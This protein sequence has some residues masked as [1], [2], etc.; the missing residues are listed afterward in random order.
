MAAW[1]RWSD[2]GLG[3]LSCATGRCFHWECHRG[4]AK[5]VFRFGYDDQT[6]GTV[7]ISM[8]QGQ[9]SRRGRGRGRKVQNP[10]AR[11]FESNGPDV[12]IRGTAAHIAEKYST[13]ARDAAASGDSVQAENYLQHAEHYNRI[14]AAAQAQQQ[15]QQQNSRDNR[16]DDYDDDDRDEREYGSSGNNG[17]GG[18]NDQQQRSNADDGTGPQPVIE[19]T[20]AEVALKQQNSRDNSN[21]SH[22]G[23]TNGSGEETAAAPSG[24]AA[25]AEG[26]EQAKPRRTRRPRRPRGESENAPSQ[27]ADGSEPAEAEPAQG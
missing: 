21:G 16:D 26:Q 22:A 3:V 1:E 14:I 20:P 23:R 18:D 27:S 11:N 5:G 15:Q 8:R 19:G 17:R 2:S 24:E 12:K 7:R 10:L 25:A 4:V 9:Q 6:T 13:L